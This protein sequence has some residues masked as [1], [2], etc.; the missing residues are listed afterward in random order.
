M[1]YTEKWFLRKCLVF[2][3]GRLEGY[4]ICWAVLR[5]YVRKYIQNYETKDLHRDMERKLYIFSSS[6]RD[7]QLMLGHLK[8]QMIFTCLFHSIIF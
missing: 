6:Q 1:F 3:T 4:I 5:H 2:I 8:K 7:D